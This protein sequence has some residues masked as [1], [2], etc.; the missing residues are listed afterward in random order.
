MTNQ[1]FQTHF[2]YWCSLTHNVDDTY[3]TNLG[4]CLGLAD[5]VIAETEKSGFE[6]NDVDRFK[7]ELVIELYRKTIHAQR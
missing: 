3:I 2:K 4:L 7:K 5:S 1:T 6:I